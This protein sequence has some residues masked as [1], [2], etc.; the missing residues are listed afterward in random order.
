VWSIQGCITYISLKKELPSQLTGMMAIRKSLA[1]REDLL[2]G[3]D[4]LRVPLYPA[5]EQSK[6]FKDPA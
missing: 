4:L 1:D 6:R 2:Q 3:H 5:T